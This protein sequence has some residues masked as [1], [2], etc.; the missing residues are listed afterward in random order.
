MIPAILAILFVISV[1]L[2][3]G[4]LVE[5]RKQE[6]KAREEFFSDAMNPTDTTLFGPGLPNATFGEDGDLYL[7]RLTNEWYVKFRGRWHYR[8]HKSA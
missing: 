1:M 6:R 3:G 8:G 2:Y 7:D 4:A 5:R